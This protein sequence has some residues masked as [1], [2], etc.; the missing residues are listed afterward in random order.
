MLAIVLSKA[1]MLA[2]DHHITDPS[3]VHQI[4]RTP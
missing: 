4:G 3:I 1:L 2:D